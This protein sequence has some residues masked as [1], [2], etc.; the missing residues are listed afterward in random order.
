M[1]EVESGEM[2]AEAIIPTE[3]IEK[4]SQ[5]LSYETRKGGKIHDLYRRHKLSIMERF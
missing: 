2:Y 3:L 1:F 5:L 4:K